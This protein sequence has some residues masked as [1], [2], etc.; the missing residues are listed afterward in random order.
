MLILRARGMLQEPPHRRFGRVA[1]TIF[2]DVMFLCD[3]GDDIEFLV[4]LGAWKTLRIFCTP[5][6]G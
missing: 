5:S 2:F 1:R 4:L 6:V 3:G